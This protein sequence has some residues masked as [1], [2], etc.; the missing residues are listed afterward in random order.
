MPG[1][2]PTTPPV[3]LPQVQRPEPGPSAPVVN[4]INFDLANLNPE[5]VA[6]AAEV[7][8]GPT[9]QNEVESYS[10]SVFDPVVR[11]FE[12]V[13]ASQ[14]IAEFID[15]LGMEEKLALGSMYAA[16]SL[17]RGHLDVKVPLTDR[18]E[19]NLDIR[20]KPNSAALRELDSPGTQ[21]LPDARQPQGTGASVGVKFQF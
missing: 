17:A 20:T 21:F 8:I 18:V 19:V 16:G 6:A 5:T 12:P 1:M 13:D 3:T 2:I 15:N 14:R 9:V 11:N 7:Q 4:E 10:T